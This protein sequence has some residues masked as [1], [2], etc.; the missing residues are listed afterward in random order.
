MNFPTSNILIE[1]INDDLCN[2]NDNST[3]DI[4]YHNDNNGND[5][6]SNDNSNNIN[7]DNS[8]NKDGNVHND[9]DHKRK[10]Y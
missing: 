7:S 5:D 6:D 3:I 1:I 9:K 8:C 2:N 10:L 4:D